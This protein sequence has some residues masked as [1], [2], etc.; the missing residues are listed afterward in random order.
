MGHKMY[1]NDNGE[2]KYFECKSL[3][4]IKNVNC[5]KKKKKLTTK[6]I[7]VKLIKL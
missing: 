5:K 1:T 3:I 4:E 2:K 6:F 7:F